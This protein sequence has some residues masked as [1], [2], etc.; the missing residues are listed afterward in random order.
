MS[1]DHQSQHH[2]CLHA[3]SWNWNTWE[4]FQSGPKWWSHTCQPSPP[5]FPGRL[6][7]LIALSWFPSRGHNCPIFFL[8][9][10]KFWHL[11]QVPRPNSGT[12]QHVVYCTVVLPS[13]IMK[14]HKLQTSWKETF[15]L[16]GWWFKGI[17]TSLVN[18]AMSTS[19]LR[20]SGV[21]GVSRWPCL[22]LMKHFW[23]PPCWQNTYELMKI[24][25][26][27]FAPDINATTG[28]RGELFCWPI[29]SWELK[30]KFKVFC[31]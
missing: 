2:E 8:M 23:G 18:S 21:L 22:L 3:I 25:E 24:D 9:Y 20:C 29:L 14:I 26:Y 28:Q 4:I 11:F 19:S 16:V 7:F 27:L 6:T 30:V 1:G 15:P 13:S 12:A 31:F 17:G 10:N 5:I